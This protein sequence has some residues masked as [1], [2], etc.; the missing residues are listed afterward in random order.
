MARYQWG[1]ETSA[2]PF[3]AAANNYNM[4]WVIVKIQ[5]RPMHIQSGYVNLWAQLIIENTNF[6]DKFVSKQEKII[7]LEVV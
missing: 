5:D 2:S 6:Q 3:S 7:S 4:F 1:Q